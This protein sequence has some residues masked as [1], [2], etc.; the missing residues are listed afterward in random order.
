[1]ARTLGA[2]W[3]WVRVVD[4]VDEDQS[5]SRGVPTT[6]VHRGVRPAPTRAS[7]SPPAEVTLGPA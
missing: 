3:F 1:M 2:I 7:C 6:S 5:L 4:E